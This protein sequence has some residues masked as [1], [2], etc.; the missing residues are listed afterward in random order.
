MEISDITRDIINNWTTDKFNRLMVE[1]QA[2]EDL[3]LTDTELDAV[4]ASR[5][6]L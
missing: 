2:L 5:S 1:L 3:T 6:T 4:N